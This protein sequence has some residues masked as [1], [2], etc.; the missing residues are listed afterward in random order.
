MKYLKTYFESLSEVTDIKE[1]EE[2]F[3]PLSDDHYLNILVKKSPFRHVHFT[4]PIMYL[5]SKEFSRDLMKKMDKVPN[6]ASK[7]STNL[8]SI[9]VIITKNT[10]DSDISVRNSSHNSFDVIKFIDELK[11]PIEYIE[12]EKGLHLRQVYVN[13]Y[14][15]ADSDYPKFIYYKDIDTL[16]QD[17]TANKNLLSLVLYFGEKDI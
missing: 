14:S 8:N 5:D 4:K 2:L 1:I 7:P 13:R 12:K 15:F 6:T 16:L 11:F 3:Y 10:L 9:Q 17:T